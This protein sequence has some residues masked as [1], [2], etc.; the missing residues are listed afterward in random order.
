MKIPINLA[1][2]PFRRDRADAGGV[3]RGGR[4][5]WRCT[6]GVLISLAIA[7]REQLAD[8]RADVGRI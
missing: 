4:R 1:S 6:L 7:D 5:C 3:R 8:V 2:Q